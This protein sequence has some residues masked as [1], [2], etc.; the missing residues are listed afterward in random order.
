[1]A[2]PMPIAAPVTTATWPFN[3]ISDPRSEQ[4]SGRRLQFFT[5]EIGEVGCLGLT[6]PILLVEPKTVKS[7]ML[8]RVNLEGGKGGEN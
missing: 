6:P 1:M 4:T 3:A 8:K 2:L 5:D 7:T